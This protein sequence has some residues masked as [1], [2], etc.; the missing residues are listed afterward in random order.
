MSALTWAPPV[1]SDP[2]SDADALD[3]LTAIRQ[4]SN[5]PTY[6]PQAF[7]ANIDGT[8][9]DELT[10]FLIRGL[11]GQVTWDSTQPTPGGLR[12]GMSAARDLV[13]G[14][15]VVA[16]YQLIR[17]REANLVLGLDPDTWCRFAVNHFV[18][19]MPSLEDLDMADARQLVGYD[20]NYLLQ[21]QP[22]DSFSW[23]GG[24]VFK[25]AVEDVFVAAGLATADL[26]EVCDFPGEWAAKTLHA[27]QPMNYPMDG[28][29]R[30]LDIVNDL[31][32]A[33]GCRQIYTAPT[34]R[35]LVEL[36]PKPASQPLRWRWAGSRAEGVSESDLDT[37]V[38]L[39]H[40]NRYTGDVWNVPNQ[41]VFIQD[42]LSFEP[43]EG[44]GQYTVDNVD[45]PPSDQTS[46]GRVVRSSQFLQA[47]GQADL[48]KQGDKIVQ[49]QLAQA[50]QIDLTTAPWPIAGHFDVFQFR[51]A[52][53][54]L[55]P[56]RRL[57]AQSWVL[58]LW[59]AP[60]TWRTYAVA[61]A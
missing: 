30:Y 31:L 25:D 43:V 46:V 38:V 42:G 51:H 3:R 48:V 15:D 19:T 17:S 58:D 22:S 35:W 14:S 23:D 59:G 52:A 26:G 50:E 2:A 56:K 27:D 9:G 6:S 29:T 40:S 11:D 10:Q 45:Q 8:L 33:S 44:S 57:Q 28:T 60:M 5:A 41:W 55:Q 4:S 16:I 47:S 49:D 34:G 7:V 39:R 18:V 12:L 24:S 21:N 32:K 37:K 20:K 61:Q 53:L 54:P 13:W 1:V 36:I